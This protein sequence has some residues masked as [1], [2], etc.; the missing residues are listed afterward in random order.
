[1]RPILLLSLFTFFLFSCKSQTYTLD[2]LPE[3]LLIFGSGGGITGE[4]NTYTLLENGQVFYSN[5]ITKESAEM[6]RLTKREA[7]SC[8]KKMEDL[9]L[10]EMSFDHPGN[11]YYFLEEVR[12]DEKY[13]VTWGSND[14]E[15]SEECKTFYKELRTTI[16]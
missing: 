7:A 5:S 13:R 1:M 8:F 16:K 15:I 14:H 4:V 11:L 12:G 6:E 3:N 2:N 10:S 9:K